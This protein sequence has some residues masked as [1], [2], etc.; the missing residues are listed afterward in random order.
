M[1]TG[2]TMV[3]NYDDINPDDYILSKSQVKRDMHALQALGESLIHMNEKQLA[4]IPLSEEM[5]D[6]IY[7][8]RKMPPKEARRRQIQYIG[9]LMREGNHEEIKAAVDKMQ[10][11]SDQYIHRQHQ[12]ER[13]RD[14][15]IE[16]DK[17]V[18]QTLVTSCPGID[19]QHLRQ[20]IR[21]AQK[22]REENKPPASARKLFGF[23][24]DQLELQD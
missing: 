13:Y 6:A 15:L 2:N 3:Y 14:L 18:F 8:A 11:R 12:I 17:Q 23:I 19:V 7:I 9:R 1:R 21:A 10:N 16:G 5:L 4:N 22:E 20:L 24:R